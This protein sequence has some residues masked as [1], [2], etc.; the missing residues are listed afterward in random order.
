[1]VIAHQGGWDEIAFLVLPLT[2]I[3]TLLAVANRRANKVAALRKQ[4]HEETDPEAFDG[5]APT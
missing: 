5:G 3:A 4:S 1:M 2:I